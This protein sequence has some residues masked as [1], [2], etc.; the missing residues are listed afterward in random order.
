MFESAGSFRAAG[1]WVTGCRALE[2]DDA[3]VPGAAGREIADRPQVRDGAQLDA[4]SYVAADEVV[5]SF[6][7]QRLDDGAA[8]PLS[9]GLGPRPERRGIE[10]VAIQHGR[11]E[12]REPFELDR[13]DTPGGGAE[14][15]VEVAAFGFVSWPGR[16]A[17]AVTR[18]PVEGSMLGVDRPYRR[19]LGRVGGGHMGTEPLDRRFMAEMEEVHDAI[20]A[21]RRK[22]SHRSVDPTPRWT[23]SR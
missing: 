18:K 8:D 2:S 23:R 1:L 7:F 4:C 21:S 11:F 15:F 9:C 3:E 19:R 17:W 5:D 13:V 6:D 14:R 22:P 12:Y 20:L 10:A 16:D